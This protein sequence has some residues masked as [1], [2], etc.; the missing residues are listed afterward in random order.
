[1][2]NR[3]QILGRQMPVPNRQY[4]GTL[5]K[6]HYSAS[7][8]LVSRQYSA[9]HS[10]SGAFMH[11]LDAVFILPSLQRRRPMK[12]PPQQH[13]RHSAPIRRRCCLRSHLHRQTWIKRAGFIITAE[14]VGRQQAAT[15]PAG[16]QQQRAGEC[17]SRQAPDPCQPAVCSRP[18]NALV[19]W[20]QR[21]TAHLR[22]PPGWPR[23]PPGRTQLGR[24]AL[25]HPPR[26]RR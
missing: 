23:R 24:C 7:A 4:N 26:P 18:R 21:C 17:C 9:L 22:P 5:A 20:Q 14:T 2:T 15:A 16:A 1:M 12:L 19:S 10:A 6:S 11:I 13:H 3:S 8:C 25:Q